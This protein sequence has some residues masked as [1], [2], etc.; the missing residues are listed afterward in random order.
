MGNRFVGLL[1]IS[2]LLLMLGGLTCSQSFQ[3]ELRNTMGTHPNRSGTEL[4][5]QAPE[6]QLFTIQKRKPKG[7]YRT[8]IEIIDNIN[9]LKS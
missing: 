6:T 8:H 7:N 9:T 5:L 4:A 3:N 2:E 1:W